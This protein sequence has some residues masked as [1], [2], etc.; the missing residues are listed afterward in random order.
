LVRVLFAI[1]TVDDLIDDARGGAL[2]ACTGVE[3]VGSTMASMP[4]Y[5]S[6]GVNKMTAQGVTKAV[7]GLRSMVSM[8]L[9][10]VEEIIIFYIGMLTNTYLCLITLAVSGSLHT[11]VNVLSDAQAGLAS[12]LKTV[13]DDIGG[14]AKSLQ[15][16]IN[17]LVSG[18]NTVLSSS[19]PKIDFSKQIAEVQNLKLPGNLTDGLQKLN[20]SIPTFADVKNFTENVI[21][22]PFEEVKTLIDKAWSN[23]TFDHTLFPVP[24]KET[25]NFCTGNNHINNFFDHLR[26]IARTAKKVFVSVLLI[27]AL[28]ACVPAAL[29]EIRR[30]ARLKVRAYKVNQYATDPIDTIYLSARPYTSDIGRWAAAKFRSTRRQVLVRWCVAYCTSLPALLLLS[31]ALAGLLSCLCQYILLKIVQREV[32]ALTAEVAEFAGD[33][34]NGLNKASSSWATGANALII[35]EGGKLNNDLFTWVNISTVAVNNTLNAFVDQTVGVLN[36]TFGGTP[37]YDPIKGVF[38]CLIGLKVQGIE[39]GLTWVHDHAHL[40]FPLLP[41]DTLTAGALLSKSNS[42]FAN[43]FNDPKATTQDDV[44]RAVNKIGDKVA[45]SIRQ[46]AIVAGMLLVAW[47]VVF[48]SGLAYVAWKVRG[49]DS[50]APEQ[51]YDP[52]QGA[53][54]FAATADKNDVRPMSPAPA[55]STA[56]A[57]VSN[58]APYTLNPHP[59]PSRQ[60]EEEYTEKT[61]GPTYD[62]YTSGSSQS[63]NPP[64]VNY[65]NNSNNNEKRGFI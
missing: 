23:Y 29:L 55:Y 5:L 65:Y 16:G 47:F 59:F 35:K 51:Y 33:V 27:L 7:A 53:D 34:V 31:I 50:V 52:R 25:L 28:V 4:H 8:T 60:Q 3:Q 19:A 58:H 57:D 42:D 43:F 40:D 17:K 37:L 10:G 32:P 45:K 46:E 22:L 20:S 30:Y 54:N 63:Q 62:N 44:S 26:Q 14:T 12:E 2:S 11:V 61:Q 39:A 9:T 49:R 24:Q 41:N 38:D 48:S 15:D 56:Q 21:R 18:I 64:S 13:G 36:K 6:Q 1:A